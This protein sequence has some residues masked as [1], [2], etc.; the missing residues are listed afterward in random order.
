MIAFLSPATF[1]L[2]F[3]YLTSPISYTLPPMISSVLMASVTAYFNYLLLRNKPPPKCS[4]IK[5]LFS[6]PMGQDCGQGT[7]GMTC[8]C[9]TMPETSD[10]DSQ[11]SGDDLITA[12]SANG[13]STSKLHV[14]GDCVGRCRCISC[15]APFLFSRESI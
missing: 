1:L 10:R 6:I 5:Q 9:P 3:S 15:P 13:R 11:T 2:C 14:E 7:A 8:I 4:G 12:T